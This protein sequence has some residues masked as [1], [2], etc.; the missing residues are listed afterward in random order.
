MDALGIELTDLLHSAADLQ[1][2][3]I[4]VP[5]IAV[6]VPVL[7]Q[8]QVPNAIL[9]V[10]VPAA[11]MPV[12]EM[13]APVLETTNDDASAASADLSPTATVAQPVQEQ[14]VQPV[15]APL[16]RKRKSEETK[17]VEGPPE[18]KKKGKG[19]VDK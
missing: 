6:E 17:P 8:S 12:L 14:S 19:C 16:N 7:E 4:Q 11:P 1:T 15:A 2:N 5:V 13:T 10:P 3:E 9:V 18:K